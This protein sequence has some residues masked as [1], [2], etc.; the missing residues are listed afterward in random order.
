MSEKIW[1]ALPDIEKAFIIFY[2]EDNIENKEKIIRVF[3][4]LKIVGF[5]ND[6]DKTTVGLKAD[7]VVAKDKDDAIKFFQKYLNE[8][9]QMLN[10]GGFD[11]IGFVYHDVSLPIA[12]IK[13]DNKYFC[14]FHLIHEISHVLMIERLGEIYDNKDNYL[15]MC[16]NAT[17]A[18]NGF[19]ANFT[20]EIIND[21]IAL[22]VFMIFNKLKGGNCKVYDDDYISTDSILNF[23]GL[24]IYSLL[25]PYLKM[26][27]LYNANII[28]KIM[29]IDNYKRYCD[30][31]QKV[32][33]NANDSNLKSDEDYRDYLKHNAVKVC[34]WQLEA[35][36]IVVGVQDNVR[37]YAKYEKKL[38]EMID[39]AAKKGL[40]RK[41]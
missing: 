37:E 32:Y 31:F 22:E 36:K 14:F 26:Q 7:F 30:L 8:L 41:L 21:C 4:E 33:E 3:N 17:T 24:D 19:E 5:S 2:G 28:S 40:V 13:I 1:E 16:T 34:K 23:A 35:Q 29:G 6:Y 15:G 12:F 10:A 25:K 38:K 11:S 18:P 9:N 20:N 39:D 27:I